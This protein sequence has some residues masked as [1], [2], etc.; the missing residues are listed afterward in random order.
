MVA[1]DRFEAPLRKTI[2][3]LGLN[4][5]AAE[6]GQDLTSKILKDDYVTSNRCR[7]PTLLR[8]LNQRRH[9][10]LPSVP[11]PSSRCQLC[12]TLDA[13]RFI[14][15]RFSPVPEAYTEFRQYKAN[16]NLR[17]ALVS[18]PQIEGREIHRVI[19]IISRLFICTTHQQAGDGLELGSQ[20]GS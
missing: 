3:S 14:L 1:G 7:Y 5:T 18:T 20:D 6:T 12:L 19:S 16:V 13:V 8:N 4:I 15:I 9:Q 11:D 10:V 2:L 17:K